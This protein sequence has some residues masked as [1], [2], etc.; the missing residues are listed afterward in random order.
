M[1]LP[2]DLLECVGLDDVRDWNLD[3]FVLSFSLACF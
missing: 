3:D 1:Q 2:P